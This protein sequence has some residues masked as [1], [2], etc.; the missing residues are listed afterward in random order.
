MLL[1]TIPLL[2]ILFISTASASPLITEVY[3]DTLLKGDPDEYIAIHNPGNEE[4]DISGWIVTDGEGKI[5]FPENTVIYPNQK[6]YIVR[7]ASYFDSIVPSFEY[8]SDSDPKVPQMS[9]KPIFLSN[10]GD[11]VILLDNEERIVDVF[12][13]GDSDYGGEGWEGDPAEKPGEGWV[14]RRMGKDTDGKEDWKKFLFGKKCFPLRTFEFYGNVTALVSPDNSFDAIKK[15]IE[16]AKHSID[17]NMYQFESIF[18][19]DAVVNAIKRGVNVRILVE[20]EP[21]GGITEEE[22]YIMNLIKENGGWVGFSDGKRLDHAKY[23]IFDNSSVL[24][25]SENWKNTGIPPNSTFGNRGW[26]VIIRNG[27]VAKYFAEVF[28]EDA[29]DAVE[30]N[31]GSSDLQIGREIPEGCYS[32]VFPPFHCEGYF[33]IVPV[34]APDTAL[35]NETIIG[36][37]NSA[38]RF[39]YIEESDLRPRWDNSKNPFLEAAIDAARRG[40][41]VKILLDPTWYHCDSENDNDECVEYVNEIA[42]EENLDLEAK[43]ADL[44]CIEKIHNKGVIVDGRKVLI[45]SINW[46]ENSP[47]RNREVGVIVINPD[48]GTYYTN[49]FLKDW[50]MGRE[51]EGKEA[52]LAIGMVILFFI[53]FFLIK[54]MA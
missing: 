17:I 39:V 48:V 26:G 2:L 46:N 42:E 36:M 37:I 22:M 21:V 31:G 35:S 6:M 52:Y 33:T 50:E 24:I 8:E 49:V 41:E 43:L 12:I 15:E 3:P 23:V 5:V 51:E 34:I 10:K 14:F 19:C 32:P 27:D 54:K 47:T 20:R 29:K 13:Y 25:L 30:F 38:S 53:V 45:S 9:G 18:L 1:K 7:N 4:I 28:S 44:D 16:N 40:C 11:E